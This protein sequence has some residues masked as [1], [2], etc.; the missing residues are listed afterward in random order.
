M[1]HKD[2]ILFYFQV[3]TASCY[4]ERGGLSTSPFGRLLGP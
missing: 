1:K 2:D 3:H 4:L